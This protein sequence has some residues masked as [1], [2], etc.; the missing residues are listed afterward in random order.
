MSAKPLELPR[1]SYLKVGIS[2]KGSPGYSNDGL[3][4]ATLADFCPLFDLPNTAFYSLQVRPEPVEIS[5]LG[6][7][8]FHC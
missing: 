1:R 7:R 8:W 3:R 2:W 4:S 6:A 5:E